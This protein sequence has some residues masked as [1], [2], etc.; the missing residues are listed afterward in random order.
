MD[1]LQRLFLWLDA[2]NRYPQE[3]DEEIKIK[4]Q[5]RIRDIQRGF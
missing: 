5:N 3:G 4:I 1:E 2:L